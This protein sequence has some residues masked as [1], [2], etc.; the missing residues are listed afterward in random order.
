L[1][2]K[3]AES[4]PNTVLLESASGRW[5]LA[6]IPK[7]ASTLLKRLA[8][9][10]DGRKPPEQAMFGETRPALAVHHP[11]QHGLKLINESLLREAKSKTYRLRLLVTR[12]PGERLLSFWHDKLYLFE[13]NYRK[14]N[15]SIQAYFSRDL[16]QPC[17]FDDFLFYLKDHWNVL[18]ID[19]HLSPQ[20]S[21]KSALGLESH[22]LEREDLVIKLPSLLNPLVS[23]QVMVSIENELLRYTTHFR[24]DLTQTWRGSYNNEKLDILKSLYSEDL[25]SFSYPLKSQAKVNK[26]LL[27]T[28]DLGALAHPVQQVRDRNN[29]IADLQKQLLDARSELNRPPLP[30][31]QSEQKNWP[32]HKS[33]RVWLDEIYDGVAEENAK[34]VLEHLAQH[35]KT[36]DDDLVRGECLYLKG[37]ALTIQGNYQESLHAH[38]SALSE[39][40]YT[41]YVLFNAG[42]SCRNINANELAID[43]FKKALTLYPDFS[44]CRHNYALAIRDQGDKSQAERMLRLLLRDHPDYLRASFS[45]AD[46][47]R[48][49]HRYEEAIE[50]YHLCLQYAPT[51]CEA[52]NNLGLVYGSLNRLDDAISA[53]LQALSI[54]SQYKQSRQN[55]AQAYVRQKCHSDA[56]TQFHIFKKL[57]LS[58]YEEVIALQG[59][60]TC[61]MELD[62]LDEAL[63]IADDSADRRIQLM[64]RLHVLPV[65]YRNEDHIY[66]VRAR[67]T[68]D[69][70]Q[71]YGLL[72][73][74]DQCDSAWELLYA[75]A[76]SI[77]NFYLPYQMGDDRSLQELYAG[78]LDRVL[79]PRLSEFMKPIKHQSCSASSVI[80]IGIVSPHLHNHNGSIWA[81][82]WLELV[83]NDERFQIYS[84]NTGETFDS[85]TQRFA[86]LGFYRQL[87][88]QSEQPE[89]MLQQILDDHLDV[90]IFT[91][92][93]MHPSSKIL[94]VLR[95]APVQIQGWG[96]PITSGSRTMDYYF[97][98]TGMEP[99]GNE[100][101]YSEVLYRLPNTGLNYE[102][103][104]AIRDG[105]Y[106]YEKFDLPRDRPLLASLQSTFKYVPSNDWIFAEIAVRS[107]QALI[108]FVGHMG[109]GGVVD[110]LIDRLRPHFEERDLDII[111]HLR[112]LP[113][114]DY[115]DYLGFLSISH[116]TIDTI[117]WN[118]GNS[119]FQSFSLGCPVVTLPT[120]FMRGRHTVSMLEVMNIPA[121]IA[122]DRADYVSIST[123]LLADSSFC[124]DIRKQIKERAHL[125][126][127]DQSV[128]EAVKRA[129]L[130]FTSI[131]H[132]VE[133]G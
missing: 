4:S 104:I 120:S 133:P 117:D 7:V 18:K 116:H 43:F 48:D 85:G 35:E 50:A 2:D 9:I 93:G 88:L 66:S 63:A 11:D 130:D 73:G 103:P 13:P 114:L 37:L 45:L 40:F 21:L 41:P 92:V 62:Q 26:R 27:R 25:E 108:L 131:S 14:L 57:D 46:L 78:V 51:Y 84:Y 113:R 79:R 99:L 39:G 42:N 54:N 98:G 123:R 70:Q 68:N 72:E 112:V 16:S 69:L 122:R 97:S 129:L 119:S 1:L 15:Y 94:S 124:E 17:D 111:N 83:A 22:H 81:L 76:W 28:V 23:P 47:L 125:L 34:F 19:V 55:L 107:P 74:L 75:H 101:H 36:I 60:I 31:L 132:S 110:R 52:W 71:L 82:G 20:F 87:H 29:Q 115:E 61:H 64:S 127:N 102:R 126:F 8:V 109:N 77:S 100:D 128:A 33:R 89:P 24:Q 80:R 58:P 106:L 12:H 90:L 121:L 32:D 10:A 30:L 91:D 56:L 86:A 95:L 67:W 53:Y 96:H 44:E 38:E 118:G 5:L 49:G 3:E 59:E 6:P 65:L 105:Q